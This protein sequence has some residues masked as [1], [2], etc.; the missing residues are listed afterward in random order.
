MSVGL[1]AV[2]VILCAVPRFKTLVPGVIQTPDNKVPELIPEGKAEATV[3]EE[4]AL[5]EMTADTPM[6][7]EEL[8]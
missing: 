3:T 5:D 8:Y 6:I 2:P 1:V 4:R 7:V